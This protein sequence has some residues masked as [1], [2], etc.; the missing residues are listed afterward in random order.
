[1]TFPFNLITVAAFIILVGL[2][3]FA[4]PFHMDLTI[5]ILILAL[6]AL[7][8]DLLVG[9][10]KMISLGHAAFFGIGAYTVALLADKADISPLFALPLSVLAAMAAAALVGVLAVR[11][12]GIYFVLITLAFS[13]A[14]YYLIHDSAFTGGSDGV[15][16]MGRGS[17]DL[18][19]L[20]V[21]NLNDERQLYFF[22]LALAAA[23]VAFLYLL[24]RS[25]F[26]Q[27]L[28]GIGLNAPRLES[29]G[30]NSQS[31]AFV[32]FVIAG[33]GAGLAGY[34]FALH[35]TFADPTLLSWHMSG[36]ILIMLVLGGSGTI[37]G[38]IL[39][40][41]LITVLEEYLGAYTSNW[42]LILGIV[43]VVFVLRVRGGV[44]PWIVASAKNLQRSARKAQP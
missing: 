41:L 11:T 20:A 14:F 34:L 35:Q 25:P 6:L 22:V 3:F 28:K 7:S 40:A 33:G 15:V 8:L 29:V 10:A 13:Q 12:R 38:P 19:G 43:L 2:P 4:S 17:Y 42:K 16:M 1:M 23:S 18:L 44:W 21:L 27:V 5:R 31:Y 37:V 30:F 24:V 36:Q 9:Y 39:G 26:G 32:A